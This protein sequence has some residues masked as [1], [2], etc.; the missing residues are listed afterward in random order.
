MIF[1]KMEKKKDEETGNSKH[2]NKESSKKK[3]RRKR[4][5]CGNQWTKKQVNTEVNSTP[6]K[7]KTGES[8]V[9]EADISVTRSAKKVTNIVATEAKGFEGYRLI[10]VSV[11]G[12]MVDLFSCPE[13]QNNGLEIHENTLKRKGLSSYIELSCTNCT[14]KYSTYT[15][16]GLSGNEQAMEV[17]VRAVYAMRRCG[18]GHKGLQKFCGVM[19]MPPPLTHK[20]YDK[21]SQKLGEVAEKV[22]KVSMIDATVEVKAIEGT[23]IGVSF[24]GTWQKRGYSSLNGVATAISVTNGKVVDCEVLSRHCKNCA[25]HTKMAE[26][27]PEKY[28]AWKVSHDESCQ[29]NHEGS[30]SSMENVA[31]VKIFSRSESNYGLR[32]LKYYGDGDS[33]AFASIEN[34]YPCAICKKIEC[35]GHYQKRVGNRLRK[36]RKRVKGLGGKAKAKEVLHTTADGKVK[37]VKEKARGK[38]TD[39]TID[40]LQNYF[41]I[42]LRSGAKTTA[43]LKSKLLASFFHVA[44]SEGHNYHNYCPSTKDTWCQFQ[45]DQIN[46]TNLHKA[47]KGLH[48]DVIKHVKP[49]YDSLTDETELAKCLHGHTQNANESFNALI[50]ERAPKIRYCGLAKLKLCVYDAVSFY[51]Y[52]GQ[53]VI[54]TLKLLDIDAGYYTRMHLSNANVFRKYTAGYK[55][56]KTSKQ[57]R[58]MIRGLK[59]KKGDS[60]KKKEGVT[61]EA[62]GF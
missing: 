18:I 8:V 4:K 22:A 62:G 56:K 3:Y 35:I 5:F 19:N 47:G 24:D 60:L 1:Y 43:E 26:S 14:F 2:C 46:G 17:N 12:E 21:V 42:A 55:G 40:N 41:G 38:L 45:R 23:D 13:C 10:D 59:K 30:A 11:L 36:L 58:K 29:L 31:A 27:D 52:G 25:D 49:V 44:S 57:R 20:N 28:A 34:I 51:N 50:W 15:S 33:S 48:P 16:K 6:N 53:S 39:A 32:Y 7:T 61:Y 37:K 54:D 9:S